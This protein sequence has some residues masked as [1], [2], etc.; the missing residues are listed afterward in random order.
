M[1]STQIWFIAKSDFKERIR[2]FSFLALCALSVLAA[3]LFVPNSEAEITSIAVDADY[4]LQGTNW[5]WIPMASALCT[6]MLLPVIGYFYLRNSLSFDRI[7]GTINLIYTSPVSKVSYLAGK[8]ISDLCLLFLILLVVIVSSFCMTLLH[9]PNSRFS[10]L[11][12][13]SFFISILPG[14]FLCSAMALVTETI[15]VLRSR[16]GSWTAGVLFFTIYIACIT[17]L[18]D[19]PHGIIARFFDM[20]GF[21]W[22]KDSIDH[23]VYYVT[24]N[25]AQ[26]ALGVYRDA[27]VSN[28][29][30]SELFFAPLF[31]TQKRVLEKGCMIVIGI[32]LVLGGSLILPRYEKSR[33]MSDFSKKGKHRKSCGHGLLFTE[34]T[35]TF[36]NCSMA[37]FIVMQLLWLSMFKM[38]IK[39]VRESLWVLAM[40]WSCIIYSDYGCREKK[41]NLD[42]LLPTYC[43]AYSLQVLIRW[44]VG[45]ILSLLISMPVIF[46]IAM[47][48][49]W[50]GSVAGIIFAFFVPALSI[51]LGQFGGSERTFEIVFLIICYLMLNS[52]SFINLPAISNK[53]YIYFI[54]IPII[55][56]LMVASSFYW[57]QKSS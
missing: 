43:H 52:T 17:S 33:K 57:R 39:T 54:F 13:L 51:F 55:S 4:F 11:H 38:D 19:Y 27:V 8:Y 24:G 47:G 7:T 50:L 48:G 23:S 2:R 42:I 16:S 1:I 31:F 12:F 3:C 44:C 56:F 35:L 34:L 22:L 18:T 49:D 21:A 15:P 32:V 40:A 10:I 46:R 6:G 20:S 41:Y 36:R 28:L 37:W 14:I 30:P 26:V 53:K 5:S 29:E 25:S 45:G 9:F